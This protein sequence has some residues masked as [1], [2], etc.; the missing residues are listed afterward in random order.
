MTAPQWATRLVERVCAEYEV[1]V[2]PMTWHRGKSRWTSGRTW[3][4]RI[5]VTAGKDA[6]DR[7]LVLLHELAHHV[8]NHTGHLKDHHSARFWTVAFDLYAAHGIPLRLAAQREGVM[9][10]QVGAQREA[11]RRR[12]RTPAPA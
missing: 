8:L 11:A 4:D 2:P 1:P 5:H 6:K 3:E 7:R 9:L 12:K 10:G